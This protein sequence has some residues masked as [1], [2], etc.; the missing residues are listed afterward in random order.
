MS[1]VDDVNALEQLATLLLDRVGLKITPDGFYGLRLALKARLPLLRLDTADA[2]VERLRSADGDSELR[3]LLPLVTIGKTEFFRDA[4]QFKSFRQAVLPQMAER[5]RSQSRRLRIWCAGCATG[6]EAYSLAMAALLAGL[7]ES[8]F[9]VVATDLNPQAVEAATRGQYAKR[10]VAGLD[11]ETLAMFFTEHNARFQVVDS[12]RRT[13]TFAAHNLARPDDLPALKEAFDVIFCRNVLIYFDQAT[14]E[15]V[16]AYFYQRLN[17]YGW[18]FLGYSETLFKI[19]TRFEMK[20][21]E[22]TFAYLRDDSAPLVRMTPLPQRKLKVGPVEPLFLSPLRAPQPLP[23]AVPSKTVAAQRAMVAPEPRVETERQVET[24][25]GA[26][27][28]VVALLDAGQFAAAEAA[29]T[30]L[31]AAMPGDIAA[32]LTLGSVYAVQGKVS[33]SKA[34]YAEVL[35]REPLCVEARVYSALASFQG[36]DYQE[37]KTEL[38]KAVFLEPDL[39]LSHCLLGMVFERLNQLPQARRSFRNAVN[40]RLKPTH[41]LV[42]HFPDLPTSNEAIAEVARYRLAALSEVSLEE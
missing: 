4:P 11:S 7:H 22:G 21:V 26:L 33:E 24:V 1:V 8:E 36:G 3:A 2:Y 38:L 6:E 40:Q 19:Y 37:A 34:I 27:D 14:V 10:R 18:L 28:N 23:K 13:I 32:L 39:S 29:A 31:V 9:E 35:I 41:V 5:A 15:R 17:S 42:G 16:I 12:L 20:D 30:T 25:F